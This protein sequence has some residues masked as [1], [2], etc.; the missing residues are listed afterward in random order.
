MFPLSRSM[1]DEMVA[2]E[3]GNLG[4]NLTKKNKIKISDYYLFAFTRV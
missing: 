3:S 1:R 2:E 4:E